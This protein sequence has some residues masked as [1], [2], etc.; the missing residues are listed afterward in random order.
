MTPT[1]LTIKIKGN[2]LIDQDFTEKIKVDDSVWTLET[3]LHDEKYIN[4]T[5]AK[6]GTDWHW[7]DSCLKGDAKINT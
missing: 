1:H 3:D 4:L 6:W 7:W 5:L 2:I